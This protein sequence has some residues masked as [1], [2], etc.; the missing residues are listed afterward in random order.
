MD[1]DGPLLLGIDVGS[2]RTKALLLDRNGTEVAVAARPTPFETAGD[3]TEATVPALLGAVANVVGELGDDRLRVAAVGV[4]GI[5]ESGAPLDGAGRPLASVIA[6]HDRR[7]EDVAERLSDRFGPDLAVRVGQRLRYV[8]SIAKLGWLVE[9]GLPRPARWLG[10]PE[11]CLHALTGAYA[12]EHS[13][14]GRTGCWDVGGRTW[15]PDVAAAAGVDVGLFPEVRPAGEPM[16]SVITTGAA[17]CGL[18]SG[19]PVTI[20]GHDHFAGVIGSGASAD[21]LANSVGTAETVVGLS[22]ELPDR[23]RAVE[24]ELAVSVFPG[25]R[26]W[27]VLASGARAGLAL[28]EAARALGRE[29]GELDELAAG[30]RPVDAPGLLES[31]ARRDP[32]ALPDAP[33]AEAWATLLDA[34]SASTADAVEAVIGLLG[35]RPRLVVFGGGSHSR[36]WLEAKAR[37]LPLPVARS[38]AREAVARGAAVLA[39]AAA[40]WWAADDAPALPLEPFAP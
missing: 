9:H 25:G 30:A 29:P 16:G 10:V 32:P 13:L 39:G 28:A 33:P 12:T 7:G 21:D 18:R 36:P 6:W 23:A 31:L 14:A 26:S 17:W 15:L 35:P 1:D 37:R 4:A 5:A 20:A 8:A 3:R 11:L 2:S 24:R 38:T 22:R 19:I 34:L 27:A 40:G